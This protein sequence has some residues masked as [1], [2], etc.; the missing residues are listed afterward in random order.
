M[1][2]IQKEHAIWIAE[3]YPNQ[4]AKIPAVG[5]LEEA[6]EL[7]H[8]ILKTEQIY[9]WGE[10]SRHKLAE[11]R[12]KIVDAIGDCG[13]FACSLCNAMQWDFEEEWELAKMSLAEE[14]NALDAAI[15]LAQAAS[16]LA[17]NPHLVASLSHYLVQLHT[18]ANC[19]GLDADVA[20]KRTWQTVKER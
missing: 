9:I 12:L 18:T 20:V 6:G 16:Y 3:K 17:L 10:D 13:I 1:R 15:K 2:T 11:L 19:L 4:P 14:T 5:C 7:V 8:G